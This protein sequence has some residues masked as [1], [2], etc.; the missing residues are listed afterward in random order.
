MEK[1]K[2]LSELIKLSSSW[3]NERAEILLDELTEKYNDDASKLSDAEKM[4]LE[5]LKV[6]VDEMD[7]ISAELD[8]IK[9]SL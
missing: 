1:L 2:E 3:Y 7:T 9:D 4:E 8:R 6:L 5:Y